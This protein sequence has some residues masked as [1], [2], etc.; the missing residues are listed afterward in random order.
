MLTNVYHLF[1]SVFRYG[2]VVQSSLSLTATCSVKESE[3]GGRCFN[4]AIY[5]GNYDKIFINILIF[6]MNKQIKVLI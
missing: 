4:E 2:I 1:L 5:V 6:V 3:S